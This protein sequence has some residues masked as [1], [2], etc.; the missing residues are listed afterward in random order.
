M[1]DNRRETQLAKVREFLKLLKD[2]PLS[3]YSV[4]AISF[5]YRSPTTGGLVTFQLFTNESMLLNHTDPN[6]MPRGVPYTQLS[7][8]EDLPLR[9]LANMVEPL[10][11][12][13]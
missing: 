9:I 4:S 2:T 11:E 13:L 6:Q 12:G 5:Q 1:S 8:I 7:D 10:L 3:Q